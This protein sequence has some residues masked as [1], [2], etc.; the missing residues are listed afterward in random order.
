MPKA[1]FAHRGKPKLKSIKSKK[2]L[3]E[4][5]QESRFGKKQKKGHAGVA[6]EYVGRT[7]AVKAQAS[8]KQLARETTIL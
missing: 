4:K 7:R 2:V 6:V 5:R 8:H 3:N 1:K